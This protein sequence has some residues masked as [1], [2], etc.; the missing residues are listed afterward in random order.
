MYLPLCFKWNVRINILFYLNSQ[1]TFSICNSSTNYQV[2]CKPAYNMKSL[3]STL[4]LFRCFTLCIQWQLRW[5]FKVH[6]ITVII[7]FTL[8][9][10]IQLLSRK[11]MTCITLR[12]GI[13]HFTWSQGLIA[14]CGA[15]C[16]TTLMG[17]HASSTTSIPP[18]NCV[19]FSTKNTQKAL[20]LWTVVLAGSLG[21]QWR[22][23]SMTPW[24][25]LWRDSP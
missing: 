24:S 3:F 15:C 16:S 1:A 23:V 12:T 20:R 17:N 25:T 21:C 19:N 14:R 10:W 22:E 13:L 11:P 2:Q 7:Y 6:G 4:L 9:S 18:E 5:E 8:Q